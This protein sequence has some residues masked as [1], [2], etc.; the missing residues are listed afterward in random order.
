MLR[1]IG[2]FSTRLLILC[3]VLSILGCA[4]SNK[5]NSN[6]GRLMFIEAN[7]NTRFDN[8]DLR[9]QVYDM[10][11]DV[12]VDLWKFYSL[13]PMAKDETRLEYILARKELD[14]NFD[15]RVD[16]IMYYNTKENLIREQARLL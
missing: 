16:R 12:Q 8:T 5:A 1:Y 14:L 9:R 10:N 11:G 3:G 4:S 15:G 2:T 13:K 7:E 6:D